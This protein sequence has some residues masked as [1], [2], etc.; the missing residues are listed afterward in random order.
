IPALVDNA[1]R[2]ALAHRSVSHL[3][4][5]VDLQEADA[6]LAPYEGGLGTGRTPATAAIYLPPRVVPDAADL[7]RA[8][9]V[10]NRSKKIVMLAGVGALG[11][12][13][14]LLAVAD[15]LASPIVKTL[16]GKAA[17]PDNHP[18]TTGGIGLLGTRPS[19]E[20]ME[21]CDALLMVGNNFPYPR[22]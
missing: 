6:A 3:T 4:F 11:A 14:E 18:L 5:P 7:Q 1:V 16:P 17:V 21:D 8:A 13:P 20:A 10:L 12:R 2:T 9:E 22:L 15:L 19:E